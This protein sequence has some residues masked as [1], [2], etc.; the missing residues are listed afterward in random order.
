MVRRLQQGERDRSGPTDGAACNGVRSYLITAAPG[1]RVSCPM[2]PTT[3]VVA[4][5]TR[6]PDRRRAKAQPPPPTIVIGEVRPDVT[7]RRRRDCRR[8]ISSSSHRCQ[9]AAS[10][11]Q[12]SSFPWHDP[13]D[14]A[15]WAP[16]RLATAWWRGSAARE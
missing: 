8:A 11:R 14:L 16:S 1:C 4:A 6:L 15:A 2:E 9:A 3:G 10:M 13:A 7:G 5:V 12:A